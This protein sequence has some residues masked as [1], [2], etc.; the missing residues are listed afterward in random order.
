ME[1]YSRLLSA[2]LGAALA[3]PSISTASI[4][5]YDSF[6]Y[7]EN[8][9]LAGQSGGGGQWSEPWSVA[10]NIT[11][12]V[13]E[14]GSV[15]FGDGSGNPLG[16]ASKESSASRSFASYSGQTVFLKFSFVLAHGTS[17]DPDRF[18]LRL[19]GRGAG[20][21]WGTLEVG[22]GLNHAFA[23]DT[24]S[25]KGDQRITARVHS[26][27]AH[28]V[29]AGGQVSDS[30]EYTVVVELSKND[31]APTSRYSTLR[32]WVNPAANDYDAAEV[33][34]ISYNQMLYSVNKLFVFL[35]ETEPGDVFRLHDVMVAT[36]WEDVTAAH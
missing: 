8:A 19:S 2:V 28:R 20:G 26:T 24:P 6:L 7:P 13:I 16:D 32:L 27:A 15:R 18:Y 22:T 4:I 36:S 3:L 17:A 33:R 12:A 11:H 35:D 1:K 25:A 9:P 23:S 10:Q 21:G 14:R 5:A 34:Q 30:V 31:P 29:A